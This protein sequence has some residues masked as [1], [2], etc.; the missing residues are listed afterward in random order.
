MF[1]Y[2]G[3]FTE[4][5]KRCHTIGWGGRPRHDMTVNP[6]RDTCVERPAATKMGA[7]INDTGNTRSTRR[8]QRNH[9]HLHKR[10]RALAT[11]DSVSTLAARLLFCLPAC[12]CVSVHLYLEHRGDRA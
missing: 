6:Q 1:F 11:I 10:V 7:M 5:V 9:L 2:A 8:R 4:R 3:R 12:Q